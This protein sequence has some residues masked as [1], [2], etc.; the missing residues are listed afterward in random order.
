MLFR[1]PLVVVSVRG[2]TLEVGSRGCGNERREHRAGESVAVDLARVIVNRAVDSAAVVLASSFQL[3]TP[4]P[5]AIPLVF[6]VILAFCARRAI[7]VKKRVFSGL[8]C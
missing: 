1:E 2:P 4:C 8:F 5:V 3:V 6:E 7:A